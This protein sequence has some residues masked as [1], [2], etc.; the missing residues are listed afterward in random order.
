MKHNPLLFISLVLISLGACKKPT[1]ATL[2]GNWADNPIHDQMIGRWYIHQKYSTNLL[3]NSDSISNQSIVYH[4]DTNSWKMDL[5]DDKIADGEYKK[6]GGF[7]L[8]YFPKESSYY[9]NDKSINIDEYEV[10]RVDSNELSMHFVKEGY[11]NVCQLNREPLVLDDTLTYTWELYIHN[12]FEQPDFYR[13]YPRINGE[14][15]GSEIIL[16]NQKWYTGKLTVS[17]LLDNEPDKSSLSVRLDKSL[18]HEYTGPANSE[19]HYQIILKDPSGK[20]IIDT[21][22]KIGKINPN[23]GASFHG[24]AIWIEYYEFEM[25]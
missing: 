14:D 9:A 23:Q 16:N 19:I 11:I 17:P 12:E 25:Y 18:I 8:S 4:L 5:T 13:I 2:Q 15:V 1:T 7:F 3:V 21:G 22:K 6:L 10:F 20:I 24:D